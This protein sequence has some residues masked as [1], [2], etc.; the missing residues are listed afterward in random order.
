MRHSHSKKCIFPKRFSQGC[1]VRW[2]RGKENQTQK[3][4]SHAAN[5]LRFILEKAPS[6]S[7]ARPREMGRWLF[8]TTPAKCFVLCVISGQA[9]VMGQEAVCAP[10]PY[11]LNSTKEETSPQQRQLFCG[12]NK[13]KGSAGT[14]CPLDWR[15]GGCC[16]QQSTCVFISVSFACVCLS[17]LISR[18]PDPD[19]THTWVQLN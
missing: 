4:L 9:C 15:S 19:Y 17:F 2:P 10:G 8:H 14:G 16:F 6:P 13:T 3:N 12:N 1:F 18:G 7:N 5:H 11:V